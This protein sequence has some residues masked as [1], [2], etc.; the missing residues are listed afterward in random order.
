MF[1]DGSVFKLDIL[2]KLSIIFIRLNVARP[3]VAEYSLWKLFL[4]V[5]FLGLQNC[6][7]VILNDL[8]IHSRNCKFIYWSTYT[9][10]RS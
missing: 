10:Q 5:V 7:M 9:F 4:C 6:L 3:T 2:N 8:L 1:A